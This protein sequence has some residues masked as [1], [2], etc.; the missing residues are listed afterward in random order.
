MNDLWTEDKYILILQ[1]MENQIPELSNATFPRVQSE[2]IPSKQ[3]MV[4]TLDQSVQETTNADLGKSMPKRKQLVA[5]SESVRSQMLVKT[6][7]RGHT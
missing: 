4:G 3:H 5:T 2:V 6:I 7:P 1:G